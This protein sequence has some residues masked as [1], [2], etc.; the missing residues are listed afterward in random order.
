MEPGTLAI[1]PNKM[2]QDSASCVFPSAE[3]KPFKAE[4]SEFYIDCYTSDAVACGFGQ[5]CKPQIAGTVQDQHC[6]I[7]A[8]VSNSHQQ[9][10]VLRPSPMG[11]RRQP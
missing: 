5:K 3:G 9:P 4:K 1:F 2:R 11:L 10:R 7:V 8:N 6:I